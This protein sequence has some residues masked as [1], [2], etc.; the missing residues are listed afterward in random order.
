MSFSPSVFWKFK[1]SFP[2]IWWHSNFYASQLRSKLFWPLFCLFLLP[3]FAETVKLVQ[4]HLSFAKFQLSQ[5]PLN[6]LWLDCI[7]FWMVLLLVILCTF[8]ILRRNKRWWLRHPVYGLRST[9]TLGGSFEVLPPTVTA[10]TPAI[11]WNVA[12]GV[13]FVAE[14]DVDGI[15]SY[16]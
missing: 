8:T 13:G 11:G 7:T 6:L 1:N 4:S 12:T 3:I 5:A 2:C 15:Y 10:A 9:D 16:I 14:Q